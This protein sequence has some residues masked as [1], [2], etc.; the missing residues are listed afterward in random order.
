MKET[1]T[2]PMDS[3]FTK[4]SA[5]A[6]TFNGT[7][8]SYDDIKKKITKYPIES[9]T[10]HSF[11]DMCYESVVSDMR[12]KERWKLLDLNLKKD[13]KNKVLEFG[14]ALAYSFL[15]YEKD[16]NLDYHIIE[17]K[18]YVKKGFA[19]IPRVSWYDY[20]PKLNDV[21][22]FYCR[23]SI[24][25]VEDWRRTISE[26]INNCSPSK[27]IWEHTPVGKMKTFY[28]V[29]HFNDSRLPWCFINFDEFN[30]HIEN[31][32]YKLTHKHNEPYNYVK[33]FNKIPTE[34]YIDSTMDLVYERE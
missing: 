24:Q 28:T 22:I 14:G 10:W 6:V 4:R 27:I 11:F 18:D 2:F 15:A 16:Y 26:L 30:T 21:D 5:F 7:Y 34:Y 33:K 12:L 1:P 29:Q 3:R 9:E 13:N 17:T 19:L 20:L 25:Y 32:G 31:H 23:G 8:D